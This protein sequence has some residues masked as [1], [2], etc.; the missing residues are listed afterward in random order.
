[1]KWFAIAVMYFSFFSLI[2]GAIYLT[3]S[4]WCLW[5]LV[6]TPAVKNH[7]DP[8]VSIDSGDED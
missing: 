1:M 4:A 3:G 2:G 8:S 6:F 7:V 5:A